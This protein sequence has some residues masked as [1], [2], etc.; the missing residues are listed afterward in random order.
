MKIT[1]HF[2]IYLLCACSLFSVGCKKADQIVK[3]SQTASPVCEPVKVFSTPVDATYIV[4]LRDG[5][6]QSGNTQTLGAGTNAVT[7]M[8]N[9]YSIAESEQVARLNYIH[10]GFVARL[11]RDQALALKQDAAVEL[12]EQDRIITMDQGC[13]LNRFSFHRTIRRE[14]HRH[15]SW[16]RE[17][18]LPHRHR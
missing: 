5:G 12:V 8:L 4:M 16:N 15:R 17:T 10:S 7:T 9:R 2:A 18:C 11:T 13:H 1:I 3:M 14:P 6:I